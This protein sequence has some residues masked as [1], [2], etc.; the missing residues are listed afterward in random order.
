MKKTF[1][2]FTFIIAQFLFT[3]LFAQEGKGKIAG[4]VIDQGEGKPMIGATVRVE[5]Q[6]LG[7]ITDVEG[8]FLIAAA[9]G[10]YT[11]LVTYIGYQS[12]R[13]EVVV[14]SGEASI[15]NIALSETVSEVKEV[16]I[17]YTVEKSSSQALMTMRRNMAQVS[18]GIS[19]DLIRKTPDRTTSDVLKRVTGASIQEG[20]F[21]V[22]RGMNDRYNAGYLD[23]ALLPSTEA[24]RKAFAF[25]VVPASL[26]DNITIIKAGS[27]DLIGD[28]GG[29]VIKINTKAV[30]ESFSSS[31][32]L[33]AQVNSI[34]TFKDFY[35]F[36]R[37]S[38]EAFNFVSAKRDLPDF[39]DN[40]L[41]SSSQFP[42]AT[43]KAAFAEITQRFNNDWS[44][45]IVTA[46]PN[47]RMS[48]SL[49][50]PILLKND[51]KLG[52][53]FA[54]NYAN[55][56]TYSLG[57]VNTYDGGGPVSAFTDNITK[58]NF[59][60]GGI[61]NL[62]YT[63]KKSQITFRNLL[64]QN[65]DNNVISRTGTSDF[66]NQATATNFAN[67]INFNRLY[68]GIVSI[69]QV[70]GDDLFRV[71]ATLNYSS[72][73]RRVPDYRIVNYAQT[74]D[75]DKPFLALGDFFNTATGRFFSDLK[76]SVYSGTAEAYKE[77]GTEKLKTEIK[78][79]YFYQQRQREFYG[80]SF[81]YGG[82]VSD[83]TL[84]PA[85]DLGQGEIG[86]SNLYL[87]EKTSDDLGYYS[88]NSTL[89]AVFAMA[90]QKFFNRLR[91][92]YGARFESINIA[93]TNQKVN[94]D[95]VAALTQNIVLPSV[96]LS[97]SLNDKTN[98]RAAYYNTVNR[99]EF[100]ELAPFAFFVFD[101]N[102]EIKG[103]RDL[104]IATLNNFDVRAEYFPSPTEIVSIGGF[105]KT[106][107]NPVEFSLDVTQ[108][109][110]TFTYENEKSATVYGLEL[111]FRKRLNFISDNRL[112]YDLTAY[113]NLSL[114][115]SQLTF[116]EG[117]QARQ[118]RPLQGQSPY[119]L[120]GGI[121]Y[122]NS[123]NGWY[124]S[125]VFNRAGRRIAFVGVDP[126]FGDTRQDIYEN[127]RS[128]I[129]AQVGKNFGDFSLKLTLGDLLHQNL[130]FYQ[131]VNDDKKY[132]G[133]VDGDRL[134]FS[135]TNGM[136]FTL[137][138]SYNF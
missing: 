115:K 28:F 21:A 110:T 117:S 52:V 129:D 33:G 5:G 128:V 102:A 133:G 106:I 127:P 34:T 36:K 118:D 57:N 47:A 107:Q 39:P 4:T 124:G 77:F 136:T 96:N 84:D 17:T 18:D 111:E 3:S 69:K 13:V 26:I 89:H 23:G 134:M 42:N 99:P 120:N 109:F 24:D 98:L 137:T 60:T 30:P 114:I 41:R 130:T 90:D 48:Y 12:Q 9:P 37:Y 94:N 116:D 113:A 105:Y 126:T 101:R 70:V 81:V 93:V 72:I 123:D 22:I 67:L 79:G 82:S 76:E 85:I 10:S 125:V 44:N 7:A 86:A 103:N 74:P 16:V 8:K 97:Y 78:V 66:A 29:G 59:S 91:A 55:T 50:F 104:Q 88:G 54:L 49:G 63:S 32:S 62:S 35:Q 132:N 14:V 25:D 6:P 58:E 68:N 119:I 135:F 95:T 56:K 40:G 64:N 122:E 73:R 121:Q 46:A 51:Q 38:G 53:V 71:H 20:K 92:V 131:D 61:L 100:R 15:S 83:A 1:Y 138:A 43:Q 27:P 80:R 75:F 108:P 45:Q 65:T 2:F 19:A 11:L 87:V 112:F 31:L